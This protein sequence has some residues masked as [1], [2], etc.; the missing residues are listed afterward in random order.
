MKKFGLIGG[1]SW[2]ST[3]EYYSWINQS[4]N[5][6]FGD[7]TNPPLYITSLNQKEIH[8]Y[9]KQDDWLSITNLY[10]EKSLELQNLGVEGI[11]FCANTP[12]KVYDEV[13]NNIKIPVVHIAD[14]VALNI[15]SHDLSKVGLL[16]T[17]FTMQEGFI[18]NR[19]IQEHNI[20]TLVPDMNFQSSIQK[21]LYEELSMGL[22]HQT[23]RHFFEAV[24][25]SLVEKGIEAVIL[26]CTE[27]PI[28]LKDTSRK[29]LL[30]D[31]MECHCK[32]IVDFIFA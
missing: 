8:H 24:I 5:Q 1:T 3:T 30:I 31:S 15:Q 13:V 16:G 32:S 17:Q 23:T 4:V 2:Y 19:L 6:R 25:D 7:N 28:L 20:E 10:V 29:T 21:Y 12:H 9:Q 27:F 14:A 26:G 22:F 18:K 11:A